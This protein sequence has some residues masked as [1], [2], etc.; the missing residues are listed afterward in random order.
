MFLTEPNW[1]VNQVDRDEYVERIAYCR[2]QFYNPK[3]DRSIIVYNKV[4]K[5]NFVTGAGQVHIKNAMNECNNEYV[6]LFDIFRNTS[7]WPWA[8]KYTCKFVPFSTG[9]FGKAVPGQFAHYDIS[10]DAYPANLWE[11]IYDCIND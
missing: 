3:R 4:D 8:E 1:D 11:T 6:G 2:N 9:A 5:T 7:P 10:H